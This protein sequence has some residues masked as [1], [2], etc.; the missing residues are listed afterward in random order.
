MTITGASIEAKS[1]VAYLLKKLGLIALVMFN[2]KIHK[3]LGG[4][5]LSS[6]VPISFP[7]KTFEL[8]KIVNQEKQILSAFCIERIG[9]KICYESKLMITI[10]RQSLC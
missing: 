8:W 1:F 2:V 3:P 4:T 5:H 7:K 10:K 9:Q 6:E